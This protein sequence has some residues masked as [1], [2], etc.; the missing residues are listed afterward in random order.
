[1]T[2]QRAIDVL[3]KERER[4]VDGKTEKKITDIIADL[5]DYMASPERGERYE[6][7]RPVAD[8]IE[9][10]DS[11]LSDNSSTLI[12]QLQKTV[13]DMI[14]G[15]AAKV[16]NWLLLFTLLFS[17]IGILVPLIWNSCNDNMWYFA[18]DSAKDIAGL[19]FG[20]AGAACA[21]GLPFSIKK[22]N[23]NT[24]FYR[25]ISITLV[26]VGCLGVGFTTLFACLIPYAG[27]KIYYTIA[28]VLSVLFAVCGAVVSAVSSS[29]G[30][31]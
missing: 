2:I 1:M 18:I 13:L 31:K 17:A 23:S 12:R 4:A 15:N 6:V 16:P 5:K 14:F 20:S 7:A 11:R 8:L 19:C 30:A 28:E 9:T 27:A 22:V 10:M 3:D 25:A 29:G 26:A 21:F 24:D